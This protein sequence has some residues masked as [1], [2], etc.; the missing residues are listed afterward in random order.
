M[1]IQPDVFN[2]LAGMDGMVEFGKILGDLGESII[3]VFDPKFPQDLGNP[4]RLFD[5]A[6]DLS[7]FLAGVLFPRKDGTELI[8]DFL[9][10][11]ELSSLGFDV[12]PERRQFRSFTSQCLKPSGGEV[13]SFRRQ[14]QGID[15][16]RHF[17][18]A[19]FGHSFMCQFQF[20]NDVIKALLECFQRVDSFSEGGFR[21]L[22]LHALGGQRFQTDEFS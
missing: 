2:F 18:T 16:N 19:F 5:H 4:A 7:V 6:P 11:L 21:L 17:P 3:G 14:Q 22:Y 9:T 10:P 20:P 15:Q 12:F 8:L 13:G 1:E